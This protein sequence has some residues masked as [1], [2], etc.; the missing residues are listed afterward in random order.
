MKSEQE[1]L[2][3]YN[4]LDLSMIIDVQIEIEKLL[5]HQMLLDNRKKKINKLK[6]NING[7]VHCL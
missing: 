6:N 5:K 1:I 3:E 4:K 7:K 2:I